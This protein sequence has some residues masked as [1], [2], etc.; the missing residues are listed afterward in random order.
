LKNLYKT[1]HV[2]LHKDKT[3]EWIAYSWSL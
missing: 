1:I 3:I 2:H